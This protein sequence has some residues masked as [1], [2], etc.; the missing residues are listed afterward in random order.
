MLLFADDTK[1]CAKS[2]SSLNDRDLLQADL[3]NIVDWRATW[4]LLQPFQ[5]RE[6]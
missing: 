2:V 4:K 6:A 1:E 5:N 3:D